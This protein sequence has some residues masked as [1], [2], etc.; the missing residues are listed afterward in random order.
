MFNKETRTHINTTTLRKK[1]PYLDFLVQ[2]GG[3]NRAEN[4]IFT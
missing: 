3:E 2:R 4:S 1:C